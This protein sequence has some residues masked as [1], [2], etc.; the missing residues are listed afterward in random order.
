[1]VLCIASKYFFYAAIMGN[2]D[3]VRYLVQYSGEKLDP[4]AEGQKYERGA[5]FQCVCKLGSVASHPSRN[6]TT[7]SRSAEAAIENAPR[8]Y[9]C[10]SALG[11]SF[12]PEY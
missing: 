8:S 11:S 6:C 2:V 3:H 7:C 9:F 10:P 5:F 4:N 1:M 12:S